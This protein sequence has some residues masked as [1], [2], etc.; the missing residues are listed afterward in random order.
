MVRYILF[1][2]PLPMSYAAFPTSSTISRRYSCPM[3]LVFPE[4]IR[5]LIQQLGKPTSDELKK[6]EVWVHAYIKVESGVDQF[7][8]S[9]QALAKFQAL[10]P[11]LDFSNVK[12]S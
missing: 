5:Q 12:I 4:L 11:E 2:P 10:H 1:S 3:H 6:H 7:P 9:P 8:E